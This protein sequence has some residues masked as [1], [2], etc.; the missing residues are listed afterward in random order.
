[1]N[2]EHEWIFEWQLEVDDFLDE[3]SSWL[4]VWIKVIPK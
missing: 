3:I 2:V 1:M 4:N